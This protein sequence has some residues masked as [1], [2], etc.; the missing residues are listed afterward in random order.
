MSSSLLVDVSTILYICISSAGPING[1]PARR[2]WRGSLGRKG[3][4]TYFSF[5][6]RSSFR[7]TSCPTSNWQ[8]ATEKWEQTAI[9]STGG[10]SSSS[11]ISRSQ[12]R[13]LQLVALAA[14]AAVL[15]TSGQHWE[16]WIERYILYYTSLKHKANQHIIRIH[17]L[18]IAPWIYSHY[19]T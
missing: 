11:K 9:E 7:S 5:F 2:R 6:F 15:H 13:E 10:S 4:K 18:A 16:R 14:A 12:K 17:F 19:S 1:R 3:S 8:P